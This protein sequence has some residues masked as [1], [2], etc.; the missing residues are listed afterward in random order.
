MSGYLIVGIAILIV[1]SN[2][3]AVTMKLRVNSMRPEDQRLSWWARDFREV[4]RAYREYYP[5]SALSEIDHYAF[6]F[7]LVAFA[8]FVLT[9]IFT[10]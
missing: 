2:A 4:N 1:I 7:L 9:S 6:Y 5:A 10:K 3:I 8:A